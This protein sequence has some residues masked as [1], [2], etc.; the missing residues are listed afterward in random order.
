MNRALVTPDLLVWARQRRGL[1]AEEIAKKLNVK[2]EAI[3]DWE[4][5]ERQPTFRQ[6]QRFAQV[7]HVPFGYLFLPSPPKQGLPIPDFR[8]VTN[9]PPNEPSPDFLDLLNDVLTKQQWFREHL[10]TEGAEPLP[11]VGRYGVDDS[12]EAIASDIRITLAVNDDLRRQSKSWE[13]FLR[14]LVRRTEDLGILVL[15]SGVVGSNNSRP[16]SV[17]EF[18][19]FAISDELAPLVFIN[20]RDF[21]AAQIFTLA[22]ELAH[23][24]IGETGVSNPDYKL[25]P[26]EQGNAVERVS[27]R[28]A[29]ETLVP[30]E[31]FLAR[32]Q[33]GS[34]PIETN[35]HSLTYHYRVSGMV[36]LRQAYDL[37][38]IPPDDYWVHYDRIV[39]RMSDVASDAEPG[40]N[41]YFTLLARNSHA[42]VSAVISSVAEGNLLFN[43]A[44]GLLNVRVSTLR[45]ISEHLF[46]DRLSLA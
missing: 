5:G 26:T 36:V 19:G 32:W 46:G 43:E 12:V 17:E 8:I 34:T 35:L 42:F 7:L 20:G 11:F 3:V 39:S 2:S 24:W 23:L 21:R 28:V 18:R 9:Q 33:N 10:E 41:F 13:G 27:N 4:A 22:H 14:E 1:S 44:A 37:E 6:A 25:R 38:L 29:A 30:S 15:R 31:D 45:G 16:L 40:G